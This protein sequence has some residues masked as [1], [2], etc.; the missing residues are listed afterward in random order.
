M[1]IQIT[2]TS[3]EVTRTMK[4]IEFFMGII[5]K[6]FGKTFSNNDLS[7]DPLMD[8]VNNNVSY[9]VGYRAEVLYTTDEMAVTISMK[10]KMH[11]ASCTFCEKVAEKATPIINFCMGSIKMI[12]SF[13]EKVAEKDVP[14]VNFFKDGIKMLEDFCKSFKSDAESI[15]NECFK[16]LEKE[17]EDSARY[18]ATCFNTIDGGLQISVF[19]RY[20]DSKITDLAYDVCNGG[21]IAFDRNQLKAFGQKIKDSKFIFNNLNEAVDEAYKMHDRLFDDQCV[22]EEEGE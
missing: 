22:Q 17:L 16:E 19:K 21:A 11:D 9:G 5:E 14:M 2:M 13:C 3:K 8:P 18:A 20:G 15:R 10:E 4:M 6:I 7:V 12:E 1:K